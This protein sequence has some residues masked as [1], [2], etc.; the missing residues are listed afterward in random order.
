MLICTS[1]DVFKFFTSDYLSAQSVVSNAMVQANR[2]VVNGRTALY[3][4]SR[5]AERE[6]PRRQRSLKMFWMAFHHRHLVK[7]CL[8]IRIRNQKSDWYI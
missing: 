8:G 6:R 5:Y 3:M 7:Y 4:Q 2:H 1:L